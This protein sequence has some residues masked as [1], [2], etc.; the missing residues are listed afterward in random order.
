MLLKRQK[1]S[2]SPL[3]RRKLNESLPLKPNKPNRN[4]SLLNSLK[5]RNLLLKRQKHNVFWPKNKGIKPTQ[6]QNP[7]LREEPQE[8]VHWILEPSL[9]P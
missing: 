7:G 5:H 6:Q 1:L 4:D 9:Q 3:N 8:E 2:E